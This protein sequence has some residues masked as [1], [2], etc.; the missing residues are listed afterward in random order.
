VV[1][2]P[3]FDDE[4]VFLVVLL[5]YSSIGT[6]GLSDLT[7]PRQFWSFSNS[8]R[9]EDYSRNIYPGCYVLDNGDSYTQLSSNIDHTIRTLFRRILMLVLLLVL[10]DYFNRCVRA[11]SLGVAA[12]KI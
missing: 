5:D 12:L 9:E 11:Y 8:C 7:S 2:R 4:I 10:V 6:Y 1:F 3:S